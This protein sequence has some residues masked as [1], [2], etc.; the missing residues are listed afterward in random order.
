MADYQ[1]EYRMSLGE[2]V[3][4]LGIHYLM[5]EEQIKQRYHEKVRQYHIDGLGPDVSIFM[6]KSS[7]EMLKNVNQ[8]YGIVQYHIKH[9]TF[10]SAYDNDTTQP[11][12][13]PVEPIRS[14]EM[15]TMQKAR[16]V[17]RERKMEA[18]RKKGKRFDTVSNPIATPEAI[19]KEEE[20]KRKNSTALVKAEAAEEE[21]GQAERVEAETIQ[22]STNDLEDMRMMGIQLQALLE[23]KYWGSK[24]NYEYVQEQVKKARF[25]QL[26]TRPFG[27]AY[28]DII[29]KLEEYLHNADVIADQILQAAATVDKAGEAVNSCE[30]KMRWIYEKRKLPKDLTWRIALYNYKDIVETLKTHG[31]EVERSYLTLKSLHN[32]VEK[33]A[34][35]LM[36]KDVQKK[37]EE[38][39]KH[40]KY[41]EDKVQSL[42]WYKKICAPWRLKVI[43]H[44][45]KPFSTIVIAALIILL[46]VRIGGPHH[47]WL[48]PQVYDL[49]YSATHIENLYDENGNLLH[50]ATPRLLKGKDLEYA[51]SDLPTAKQM[52]E[53]V[54]AQEARGVR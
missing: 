46:A 29:G 44:G 41:T 35:G 48:Y 2:A 36:R 16:R 6:K 45:T 3:Q 9:G 8:A 17:L 26:Y 4:T 14:D 50:S 53:R 54:K 38:A 13:H 43:I 30:Y 7:E 24:Y 34:H 25:M 21:S 52:V 32:D 42:R 31:K 1:N 20:E 23:E 11:E 39:E 40:A 51:S 5:D 15:D 12:D 47:G 19:A 18:Q 33:K 49:V 27:D 10:S 37:W 22:V 28:N